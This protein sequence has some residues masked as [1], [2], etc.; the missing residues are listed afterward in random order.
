MGN[1]VEKTAEMQDF[2]RF[3]SGWGVHSLFPHRLLMHAP[4]AQ[5]AE[6]RGA[7]CL[8]DI[9]VG[10]RFQLESV[11]LLVEQFVER[12]GLGFDFILEAFVKRRFQ[13]KFILPM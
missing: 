9:V 13:P 11:R 7:H 10:E 5:P 2:R 12:A 4:P 8:A 6:E 1:E 3:F